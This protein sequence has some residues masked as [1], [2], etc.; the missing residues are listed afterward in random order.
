MS[1]ENDEGVNF[2]LPYGEWIRL[3]GAHGF[4]VEDLV[5]LRPPPAAKTTYD[6]VTLE[7]ARRWPAEHIWKVR[8]TDR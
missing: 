8:K 7:W 3:F 5:E 1:F 6:L 4:M 2:Q